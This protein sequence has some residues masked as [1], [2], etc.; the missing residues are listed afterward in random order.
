MRFEVHLN[1]SYNNSIYQ[2]TSIYIKMKTKTNTKKKNQ[3][4]KR[5]KMNLVVKQLKCLIVNTTMSICPIL[6]FWAQLDL[7]VG[8]FAFLT[9][10]KK[11][12]FFWMKCKKCA[13]CECESLDD[14]YKILC[15]L[16]EHF[17]KDFRIYL[18]FWIKKQVND[19]F[20]FRQVASKEFN[21]LQF[22][23]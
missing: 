12:F 7:A 11:F 23:K 19:G 18:F 13:A 2:N 16:H 3:R 4:K 20:C 1:H 9:L 17:R 22:T 15:I 10:N 6:S 5:R 21:L 8:R 14:V